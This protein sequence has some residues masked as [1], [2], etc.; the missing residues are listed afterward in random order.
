MV[1]PLR[2]ARRVCRRVRVALWLLGCWPTCGRTAVGMALLCNLPRGHAG[3]HGHVG[4]DR[5]GFPRV[6][7]RW[8]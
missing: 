2:A 4:F 5:A 8:P 3:D 1:R 7:A 6:L